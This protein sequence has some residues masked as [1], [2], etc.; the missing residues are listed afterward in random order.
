MS[1]NVV[2]SILHKWV[3]QTVTDLVL[4]SQEIFMEKVGQTNPKSY[5]CVS[6]HADTVLVAS[7]LIHVIYAAIPKQ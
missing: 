6:S 1:L 2:C 7:L 4:F 3:Q 5:L